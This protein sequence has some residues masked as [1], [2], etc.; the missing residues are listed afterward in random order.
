M[1]TMK[2]RFFYIVA[3]SFV[4]GMISCNNEWKDEQYEQYVSFKSPIGSNGVTDI[5]VRYNPDGKVTYQLPVEVS[6]STFNEKNLN[7]EVEVDNDTL[8]ILNEA[9]FGREDLYFLQMQPESYSFPSNLNIPQGTSIVNMPIEFNLTGM[10]LVQNHVL[11]LSVVDKPGI[12]NAHPRKNYAKALLNVKPFNDYSGTYETSLM[13]VFMYNSDATDY[14]GNYNMS[15]PII[16][17]NRTAR[18]VDAN[19]VFFYAGVMDEDLINRKDY[20]I[21]F[22]F[23]PTDPEDPTKGLV[24]LSTDNALINLVQN[25]KNTSKYSVFEIMDVEKPYLKRRFIQFNI[26]YNFTDYTS[27]EGKNLM[28]KV[29]GIMT[30]ERR[31]NTQIPDEDQAIMW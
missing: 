25:N 28:Y 10:D 17:N 12:Y 6:G 8:N 16:Q 7:V 1:I 2:S 11:P 4:F 19:S 15:N 14:S 9:R 24:E 29:T 31:L 13:Q 23:I 21:K 20:K 27:V 18:V 5:Y 3:L 30:L 22:K 26:D